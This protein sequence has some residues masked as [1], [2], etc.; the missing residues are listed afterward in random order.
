MRQT[1]NDSRRRLAGMALTLAAAWLASHACQAGGPAYHGSAYRG[2]GGCAPSPGCNG[3]E[4]RGHHHHGC[5]HGCGHHHGC[6]HCGGHGCG[7]CCAHG[8]C[9]GHWLHH[10]VIEKRYFLRSQ[11][12]SW[13]SAWYDPAEGR[14]IALV[15]PP[16]AEFQSQYGWG[17]PSSRVAPIY[18]QFRRPYPGPGGVVGSGGRFLPTPNQPS[19]TV[20]FGVNAVRGPWGGY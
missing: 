11:G 14:P 4:C 2:S 7:H 6:G 1:M 17:V 8:L 9:D 15:V 16:T 3:P 20:Q 5:Q 12:K 18:H 19:D 13:H 10:D